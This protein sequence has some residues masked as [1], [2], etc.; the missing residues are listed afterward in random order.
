MQLNTKYSVILSTWRQRSTERQETKL[1]EYFTPSHDSMGIHVWCP[2]SSVLGL[3]FELY[4]T[5]TCLYNFDLHKPHFYI[6]KLGFTGVYIIVF[7]TLLKNIDCGYSLGSHNPYFEQKY[8]TYQRFLSESFQILEVKFSIYLN[9]RVFVMSTFKQ[10]LLGKKS[11]P[12]QSSR[13]EF[14]EFVHVQ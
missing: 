8:E 3:K 13:L 11:I 9:R 5:K 12:N 14:I 7:L 6:I 1:F 10:D 2:A 4:I